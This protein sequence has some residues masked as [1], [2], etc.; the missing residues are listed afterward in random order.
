MF[1]KIPSLQV[2]HNGYQNSVGNIDIVNKQRYTKLILYFYGM[3]AA[4]AFSDEFSEMN[5]S[6]VLN[7]M[8]DSYLK[9]N[10]NSFL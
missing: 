10:K 2:L 7:N 5:A 4:A 9:I 1:H 6:P 8:Q 3:I